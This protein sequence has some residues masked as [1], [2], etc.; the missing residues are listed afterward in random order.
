MVACQHL[1]L[2][3]YVRG[4]V[5]SFMRWLPRPALGPIACSDGALG[6]LYGPIDLLT[7]I[8]LDPSATPHFY[9]SQLG[10]G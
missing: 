4:A 10:G 3:G 8:E 2:S 6:I 9:P 5:S 1:L 7:T